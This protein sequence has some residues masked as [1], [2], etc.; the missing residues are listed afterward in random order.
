LNERVSPD[1]LK[2]GAAFRAQTATK[3]ADGTYTTANISVGW[4]GG[5]PF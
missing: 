4:D 3:Q 5:R 1:D 2:A